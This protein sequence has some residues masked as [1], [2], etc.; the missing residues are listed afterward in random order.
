MESRGGRACLAATFSSLIRGILGRQDLRVAGQARTAKG[1]VVTYR[2]SLVLF[3]IVATG[4]ALAQDADEI[5]A[6]FVEARGGQ[7][8]LDALQSVRASGTAQSRR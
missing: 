4:G 8:A 5:V 6:K 1:G 7:E 3:L 2:I